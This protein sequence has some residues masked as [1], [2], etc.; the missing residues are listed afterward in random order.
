MN[1]RTVFGGNPSRRS[2]LIVQTE[3]SR[4][5]ATMKPLSI[6]MPRAFPFHPSLG[7][8]GISAPSTFPLPDRSIAAI[9]H[10]IATLST[11]VPASIKTCKNASPAAGDAA[12]EDVNTPRSGAVAAAVELRAHIVHLLGLS[13]PVVL[14]IRHWCVIHLE[15]CLAET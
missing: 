14:G 13:H 2:A 11:A 6:C 9:Q 1:R 5:I 3:T 7:A 10:T 8:V 12:S 4:S 15:S